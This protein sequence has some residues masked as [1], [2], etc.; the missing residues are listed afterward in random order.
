MSVHEKAFF[1]KIKKNKFKVKTICLI[2][3]QKGDKIEAARWRC[4]F[5][6]RAL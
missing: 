4:G 6:F 3:P 2:R 5:R 1:K